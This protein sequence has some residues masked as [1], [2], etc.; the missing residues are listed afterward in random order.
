MS[1]AKIR[2]AR[3]D[4]LV[5]LVAIEV[6]AGAPF[7]DLGM[8]AVADDAPPAVAALAQFQAAGRAWVITLDDDD[9]PVGYLTLGVVDGAAHVEQV[10]LR[11]AYARRGLGRRLVEHAAAWARAAGYPALT[12]TSFA[13]VPWNGPYYARLG[14]RVVPD[15]ALTPGLRRLRALEAGRGLDGGPR[16]GVRRERGVVG[17]NDPRVRGFAD[18][19]ST[20]SPGPPGASGP[21]FAGSASASRTV[22]CHTKFMDRRYVH[23]RRGGAGVTHLRGGAAARRL[24]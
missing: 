24:R 14:F 7:R 3:S 1:T 9:A 16:V 12:L 20:R 21:R 11:P 19:R 18:N 13:E 15:E 10:S 8:H 22:S 5:R 4:D 2:P 6:E 23:T 17:C